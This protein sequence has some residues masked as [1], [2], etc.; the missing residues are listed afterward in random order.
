MLRIQ[1]TLTHTLETFEPIKGKLVNLY[2]CG[3]TVYDVAHIGNLR[4]YI[5]ADVL[6]RALEL[7]GCPVRWVMNITDVDD[8]TIKRTIEKYGAEADT[9]KLREYT[10]AYFEKFKED[11][12]AINIPANK[13]EFIRVSDKMEAIKKFIKEL[14]ALGFA[15]KTE[16]GVYFSIEKYQEKFGDYGTLVGAGFLEGKK[17]GARV[18]VDEYEKD[19]LSDFALWKGRDATDGNIFWS[20]AE[21]GD[22][23]PGWH[24][25]CSVIN[26]EA[27]GD[28][29]TDIHTGGVDLIFPH[30]TNE[31]A[32]S[33]PLY[34][35]F[36]RYWAHC[37]HL[38][39]D[40]KK[41]AKRDGNFYTLQDLQKE[42]LDAGNAFRYLTL[43]S[44]Y[45]SQMNFTKEALKAAE[46]GLKNLSKAH[47]LAPHSE[48]AETD[49]E[50]I[51][52]DALNDD[53]NTAKAL[54]ILQQLVGRKNT[55]ARAEKM[56]D[57]LG[58]QFIEHREAEIPPEVLEL[59]RKR[60]EYRRNKQFTQADLLRNEIDAL[61]YEVEDAEAGPVVRKK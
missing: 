49:Q 60:E 11:L 46:S 10:E 38:L 24:I 26:R 42:M 45:R 55:E 39:V 19:N 56:A 33:Q 4:S 32:Q 35:P 52:A 47:Y 41:M 51:F 15:Y 57:A 36:S 20:D 50:Q 58:I 9:E 7:N 6:R 18:K 30:H 13:I 21:L 54:S 53:L 16:D 61:G 5:F 48:P 22:G 25:E 1:N 8:K 29:S 40:N 12:E 31:I 28:T 14:I 27:F 37:E 44:N 59:A 2:T 23:R 17:V 3:P 43:M 34:K